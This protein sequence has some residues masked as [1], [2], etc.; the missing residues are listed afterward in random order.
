M[1]SGI[2]TSP[3]GGNGGHPFDEV[4]VREIS[5]NAWD[6]IDL[7]VINKKCYGNSRGGWSKDGM[8]L[9]QDEYICRIDWNHDDMVNYLK[10]TTNFGRSIEGGKRVGTAGHIENIRLL[11]ISGRVGGKVDQLTFKYI[12]NYSAS[13]VVEE[14]ASFIVSYTAPFQ[15]F[16]SYTERS[17]R[18][19]QAFEEVS[20]IMTRGSFSS[21]VEAEFVAKFSTSTEFEFKN[22]TISKIRNEVE[23]HLKSGSKIERTVKEDHVGVNVVSG[24]LMSSPEGAHWMFP[25][26]VPSFAILKQSETEGLLGSY[27]LTGALAIQVPALAKRKTKLHGYVYFQPDDQD[28]SKA[29]S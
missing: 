8:L 5:L 11:A 25:T 21:S 16:T 24:T 14:N 20:D 10:F 26:T 28:A 2:T 22:S 29:A 3:V 7:I 13:T 12:T 23:E 18:S 4:Y 9:G 15:T 19:L 27:D 17:T 6:Q 1:A